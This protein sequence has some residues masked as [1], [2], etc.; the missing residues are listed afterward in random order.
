MSSGYNRQ[1]SVLYNRPTGVGIPIVLYAGNAAVYCEAVYNII[2]K[3]LDVEI[4]L[5]SVELNSDG[6]CNSCDG[7]AK[8]KFSLTTISCGDKVFYS[9]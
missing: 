9:S 1:S 5:Y 2:W 3:Y 4:D 6:M 7:A 8:C